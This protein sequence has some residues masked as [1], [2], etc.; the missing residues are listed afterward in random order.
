MTMFVENRAR[1]GDRRQRDLG[2]PVGNCERRQVADRRLPKVEEFSISESDWQKLFGQRL[3][4][5]MAAEG[6]VTSSRKSP[7]TPRSV[8]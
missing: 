1:A 5:E 7:K 6:G 4:S 3:A 8:H 2:P